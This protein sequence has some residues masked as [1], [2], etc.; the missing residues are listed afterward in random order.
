MRLWTRWSRFSSVKKLLILT[1]LSICVVQAVVL[2]LAVEIAALTAVE[3]LK[4][5]VLLPN[6]GALQVVAVFVDTTLSLRDA[7]MDILQLMAT[8]ILLDAVYQECGGFAHGFGRGYASGR[9][10][11]TNTKRSK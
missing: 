1:R 11:C 7:D 10:C 3:I 8:T 4:V 9:G 6:V 2:V 5:K